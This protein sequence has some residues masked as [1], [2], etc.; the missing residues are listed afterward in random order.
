MYFVNNAISPN[1][2]A[3]GITSRQLFTPGRMGIVGKVANSLKHPRLVFPVDVCKLFFGA[4]Q[5]FEGVA[6]AL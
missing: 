3:P 4:T 5:D 1:A 6:H 2:N